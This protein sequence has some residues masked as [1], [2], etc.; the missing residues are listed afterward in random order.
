MSLYFYG[1]TYLH[2]SSGPNEVFA[3]I[4]PSAQEIREIFSPQVILCVSSETEVTVENPC[5]I[6]EKPQLAGKNIAYR[7]KM[8]LSLLSPPYCFVF[9]GD[10]SLRNLL[11]LSFLGTKPLTIFKCR[12]AVGQLSVNCWYTAGRQLADCIPTD[13]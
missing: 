6:P 10:Q 5:R 1:V 13:F 7:R 9:F 2:V 12:F 8:I 4:T 11:C 3:V